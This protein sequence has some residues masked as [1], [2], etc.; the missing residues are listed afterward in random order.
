MICPRC[1]NEMTKTETPGGYVCLHCGKGSRDVTPEPVHVEPVTKNADY[2]IIAEM[3]Q[4]CP[5]CNA[6]HRVYLCEDLTVT[7]RSKEMGTFF[8]HK[9]DDTRRFTNSFNMLTD[10]IW[11]NIDYHM[12]KAIQDIYGKK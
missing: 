12:H 7:D 2:E 3:E 5:F 11:D 4:Y 9:D 10:Q 8:C 6:N 1:N